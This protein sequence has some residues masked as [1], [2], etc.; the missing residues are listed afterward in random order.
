MEDTRPGIPGKRTGDYVMKNFDAIKAMQLAHYDQLPIYDASLYKNEAAKPYG[1]T[2][3][4]KQRV[5]RDQQ[6]IAQE[7]AKQLA[8]ERY[9]KKNYYK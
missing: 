4:D 5:I 9:K 2:E 3:A 6:I 7:K 8:K 1:F